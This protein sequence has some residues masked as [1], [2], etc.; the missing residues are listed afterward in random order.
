MK[1]FET[2]IVGLF[3]VTVIGADYYISHLAL[4]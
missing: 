4:L 2:F 1:V 3:K